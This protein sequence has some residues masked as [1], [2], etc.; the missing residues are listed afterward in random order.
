MDPPFD[1]V[2]VLDGEG[3][4]RKCLWWGVTVAVTHIGRMWRRRG[5][6]LFCFLKS[7]I[8]LSSNSNVLHYEPQLNPAGGNPVSAMPYFS[9]HGGVRLGAE[10]LKRFL[11]SSPTL[12]TAVFLVSPC[13]PGWWENVRSWAGICMGCVWERGVFGAPESPLCLG[14]SLCRDL[15]GSPPWSFCC[16]GERRDA[17]ENG[18]QV[19]RSLWPS[20]LSPSPPWQ[21]IS[22]AVTCSSHTPSLLRSAASLRSSLFLR[23]IHGWLGRKGTIAL[24]FL[25]ISFY[26][27][28]GN[29]NITLLSSTATVT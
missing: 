2:T 18:L 6:M 12:V 14:S 21:A 5:L 9:G 23:P 1:S 27:P 13:T 20:D 3:P 26:W 7:S 24:V 8:F 25:K 11:L 17:S 4:L 19:R 29:R 15:T 22:S 28:K 16:L 10:Y